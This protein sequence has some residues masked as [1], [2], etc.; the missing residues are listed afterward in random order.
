MVENLEY[1]FDDIE[2]CECI[3][4]FEDEYVYD[5]EVDDDTHTFIGSDILI[6]NSLYISFAPMM[7]SVAFD[8][9]GLEFI[10]T[11]D[12]IFI[13]DMYNRWL[14]E[15]AKNYMVK[16]IHDFELET[17]N[18]TA[19]HLGKKMYINNA[20]YDD[21]I[22][23]DDMENFKPKGI[24]IVRSSTPLF[25]RGK[26]QKGGIW[27]FLDYMFRNPDPKNMDINDLLRILKDIKKQFVASDIESISCN[28]N[29]S[30]YKDKCLDDQNMISCVKACHHSV[31]SS[32]FH[33]YLLNKNSEFKTKYD[34]L[35]SGKIKWYFCKHPLNDRFAYL[36]SFHPY[37][38]V[39]KEKVILDYDKQFEIAY[40]AICNRFVKAVGLPVVNTRLSV[41]HNLM[42]FG[43]GQKSLIES[44]KANKSDIEDLDDIIDEWDW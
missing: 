20:V 44:L 9:D 41:L 42:D 38:I 22:F 6:H 1:I 13:K 36:R 33:N 12:R 28:T 29:L 25:T 35:K 18:K 3:G 15:Y 17:I 40:L 31:K 14:D 30:N 2:S 21:G 24:D 23:Y 39:E 37:E 8:G 32:A 26:K 7:K 27:T 4:M 10:L 43:N 16:N 5:I 19:L 11:M 34:L